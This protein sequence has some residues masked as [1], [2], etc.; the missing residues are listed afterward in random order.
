MRPWVTFHN[1]LLYTARNI[2]P[3]N[4]EAGGTLLIF[5]SRLIIQ[6]RIS[7]KF[8]PCFKMLYIR[9]HNT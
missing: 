5:R 2:S 9:N 6:Y 4:P 3:S 1:T 7:T 8:V